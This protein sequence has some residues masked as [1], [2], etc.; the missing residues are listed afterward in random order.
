MCGIAGI[1]A[2]SGIEHRQLEAMSGVLHHRGPDGYG[3]MLCTR[4]LKARVWHNSPIP[5]D[6]PG[7]NV[8]GFAHRRLAVIDT[9]DASLQPLID[10]SGRYCLVYNGEIYNYL[11]L[12]A[13]LR[14][15]GHRFRTTG[16]AEVLLHAYME[17]GA[18]CLP[19]LNGMWAFVLLDLHRR[20]VIFSRDR[21]GIKP[22]HYAVRGGALYFASEIKGLLAIS[23][24]TREPNEPVIADYL[25]AGIV[26]ATETFFNGIRQFP[27]ACWAEAPLL[28]YHSDLRPHPYWS[29]RPES[30]RGGWRDAVDRFRSLFFDALKIHARS[31]VPI[32]TCLSGG[33]DSSAIVCASDSLRRTG[34]MPR[35]RHT[36]V[37]YDSMEEPYSEKKYMEAVVS[38]TG[39]KMN[40]VAVSPDEL[41]RCLPEIL[42][43]QDEPFGSASAAVQWF[44][45]RRASEEGLTVM[46]DGQGAD[47]ILAGYHDF[48]R[49]HAIGLLSEKRILRF[50]SL[51]ARYRNAHGDFPL[52]W[53]R[54]MLALLPNVLA[55]L[56]IRMARSLR[57]QAVPDPSG[58]T[59]II[60][61]VAPGLGTGL[62]AGVCRRPP[63]SLNDALQTRLQANLPELL[64]YEDRNSMHHSIEARVPFLDCRLVDFAFSLRA[65]WKIRGL[66]TKYI[67]REALKD[68]LPETVRERRDKIGFRPAASLTFALAER[69]RESLGGNLTEYEKKWFDSNAVDGLFQRSDRS[70]AAEFRLWRLMNLKLWVRRFWG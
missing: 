6:V 22:L 18:A 13:E 29:V 21:F 32:G 7:G 12:R 26:D 33:L 61:R 68:L 15:L 47:E 70:V 46:L 41:A 3:Y 30:F 51:R 4:D 28:E 65:E 10:E 63:A 25:A 42:D 67:M 43:A 39:V 48:Y 27:A 50:L 1:I 62:S 17:W 60:G 53:R 56:L 5:A 16:D 24:L 66:Q 36:A 8:V 38:A 64:R 49:D 57:A 20:K 40:Y 37:S 59:A 52:S 44:V 35:Y 55:D 11:E 69:Q 31:D 34:E 54:S 45:F 19:K 2:G 14:K 9:S 23:E 58:E